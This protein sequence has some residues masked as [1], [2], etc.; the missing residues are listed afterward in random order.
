MFQTTS[1][2]FSYPNYYIGRQFLYQH[3]RYPNIQGQQ[4]LE[5]GMLSHSK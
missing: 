4:Q 2:I 1:Y 3:Y 5:I